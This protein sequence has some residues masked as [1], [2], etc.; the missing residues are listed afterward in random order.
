MRWL[1]YG[2]KFP[3]QVY[4]TQPLPLAIFEYQIIKAATIT[5]DTIIT[6][7]SPPVKLIVD[8]ATLA[9]WMPVN[10]TPSSEAINR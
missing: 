6:A 5:G 4:L 10:N 3:C 8:M 1:Q 7:I 2:P 9:V